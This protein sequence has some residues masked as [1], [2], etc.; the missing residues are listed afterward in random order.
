MAEQQLTLLKV[1]DLRQKTQFKVDDLYLN[2]YA[3]VC[4]ANATLVYM[5]LCRHAEFESQK[6]F[7]SQNKIA[8]EL[9]ISVASAKR[10]I[11][12]LVKYNIIDIRK[13]K[14]EGKFSN[15]VYYLLDK[16]EWEPTVA[17][18]ELRQKPQLKNHSS[19]T[20]AHTDTQ[21]DNKKRR[22]TNT[23]DNKKRERELTPSEQARLLF[24]G[25]NAFKGK[26]VSWIVEN[27]VPE[28]MAENE[29]NKF[30]SYWT[31]RNKSGTKER[32]ELQKTFEVKRRLATW[33]SRV[34]E[35]QGRAQGREI[36]I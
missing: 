24:S 1:R 25:N 22:I 12:E 3:R 30:A 7:P 21:K 15:N 13:E 27:G 6:A 8:F 28:R 5:S 11:K 4:G 2:G 17:P 9:G 34:K 36:L 26:I 35:F 23:K 18:T 19:K 32:W 31:E 33:F 29:L 16:S 20:I 10:G 14:M